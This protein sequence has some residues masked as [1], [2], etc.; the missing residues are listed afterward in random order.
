[1]CF[2]HF[3][4][5]NVAQCMT[6]IKTNAQLGEFSPRCNATV[7]NTPPLPSRQ[8]GSQPGRTEQVNMYK[9]WR[10]SAP[11]PSENQPTMRVNSGQTEECNTEEATI[12]H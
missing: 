1:M 10:K 3:F 6:S 11:E 12:S 5:I 2:L 4:S 9:K 7:C 8:I